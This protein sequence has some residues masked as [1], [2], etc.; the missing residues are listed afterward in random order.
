MA[1]F[2]PHFDRILDDD[3][4]AQKGSMLVLLSVVSFVL[5][6][7]GIALTLFSSPLSWFDP[8]TMVTLFLVVFVGGLGAAALAWRRRERP[9]MARS[10]VVAHMVFVLILSYVL[11]SY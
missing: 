1:D 9:H 3:A 4:A 8:M 10:L 11:L 6:L 2:D 7:A 5:G